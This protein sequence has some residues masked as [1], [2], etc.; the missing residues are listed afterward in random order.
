MLFFIITPI[1]IKKKGVADS[2]YDLIIL[3]FV[4]WILDCLNYLLILTVPS[5]GAHS[6]ASVADA[7]S[8]RYSLFPVTPLSYLNSAM[9]EKTNFLYK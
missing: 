5:L 3:D 9:P 2:G 4:F 7:G 6:L 8:H 1:S